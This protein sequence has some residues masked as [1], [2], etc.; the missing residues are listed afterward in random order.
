MDNS[1]VYAHLSESLKSAFAEFG[2][3]LP[4]DKIKLNYGNPFEGIVG[5]SADADGN[6]TDLQ[7]QLSV[8][9]ADILKILKQYKVDFAVSEDNGWA[10]R[11]SVSEETVKAILADRELVPKETADLLNKCVSFRRCRAEFFIGF[12]KDNKLSKLS[13]VVD[14]EINIDVEKSLT[15]PVSL[16][17][18]FKLEVIEEQEISADKVTLPSDLDTYTDLDERLG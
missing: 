9:I 16:S 4:S 8:E 18:S 17:G 11:I 12:D 6:A 7:A 1:N 13:S 3:E 10:L 14:V 2:V 5:Y 15:V